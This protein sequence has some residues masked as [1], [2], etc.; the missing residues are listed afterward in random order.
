M[1]YSSVHDNDD[2]DGITGNIGCSSAVAREAAPSLATNVHNIDIASRMPPGA[3]NLRS[4]TSAMGRGPN[5][6]DD[7]ESAH[8]LE[9]GDDIN[10]NISRVT[11]APRY[12]RKSSDA[13]RSE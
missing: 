11:D 1:W 8:R 6:E 9:D 2:Q 3:V 10:R 12:Q 7:G 4:V 13:T 5:H